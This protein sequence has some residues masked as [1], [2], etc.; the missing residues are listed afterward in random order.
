MT[1][2]QSE[3][4]TNGYGLF[5]LKPHQEGSVLGS[6]WGS[7]Y[8]VDPAKQDPSNSHRI[9]GTD[10]YRVKDGVKEFLQLDGSQYCCATFANDP[11]S[12]KKNTQVYKPNG[13]LITLDNFDGKTIMNMVYIRATRNIEKGSEIFINY[14]SNFFKE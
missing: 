4:A 9:I 6:Y 2:K 3:S 12:L 1:M 14:G 8:F 11:R 7:I 5:A 13:E 10:K